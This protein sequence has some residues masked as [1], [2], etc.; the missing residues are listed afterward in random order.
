MSI[1]FKENEFQESIFLNK[2]IGVDIDF[3]SIFLLYFFYIKQFLLIL[4]LTR[5]FII[6]IKNA[7]TEKLIVTFEF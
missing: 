2:K 4:E 6:E 1:L 5:I 7:L 3:L